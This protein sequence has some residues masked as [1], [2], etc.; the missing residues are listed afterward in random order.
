MEIQIG[1]RWIEEPL[2]VV[3]SRQ[4]EFARAV[5]FLFLRAQETRRVNVG[6]NGNAVFIAKPE[7]EAADKPDLLGKR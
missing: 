4:F 2:L 7:A 5:P 6:L 1:L 3:F